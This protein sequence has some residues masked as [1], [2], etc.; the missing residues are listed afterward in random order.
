MRRL[1]FAALAV[2][3][4]AVAAPAS[5][6]TYTVWA[7][8]KAFPLPAPAPESTGLDD[9]FPRTITIHKGDRVTVKNFAFHTATFPGTQSPGDL[10]ILGPDTTGGTYA[11]TPNDFAGQPWY[12]EALPKFVYRLAGFVPTGTHD[13]RSARSFVNSGLLQGPDENTPGSFTFGFPKLGTFTAICVIHPDMT[14]RV[15]VKP[16]LAKV[17]TPAQTRAK[18]NRQYRASYAEAAALA[19]TVVPASTVYAGIGDRTTLLSFLPASLTVP[20][21]T[22]VTF[23]SQ[24]AAEPHNPLFAPESELTD[25]SSW[26]SQFLAATELMPQAPGDPNQLQP[27][28]IYG[29]DAPDGNGVYTFTGSNHGNGVFATPLI[30]D[31]PS[32]PMPKSVKVKFTTPGTYHYICQLH[33]FMTGQVTVTP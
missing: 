8:A 33:P 24:T 25:P 29:S 22:T 10:F 26:L 9:F 31:N 1:L 23:E 15:T 28:F 5:A 2:V 16:K 3:V 27:F 17:P 12:F 19:K 14:L 30:L 20:A 13:V 7:D 32:A 21:G 4:L 18:A 6:A 11:D